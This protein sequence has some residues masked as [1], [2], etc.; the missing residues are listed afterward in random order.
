[1]ISAGL[2]D[3]SVSRSAKKLD[4]GIPVPSDGEHTI[5]VWMDALANYLTVA[6]YPEKMVGEDGESNGGGAATVQV[7]GKDILKFHAIYWPAFLLAAGL[8]LPTTIVAHAHWTLDGKK[9]AKSTG[10]TVDPVEKLD[11]YGTDQLRFF[12]LREGR[13]QDDADFTESKVVASVDELANKLGNLFS[14]STG[15]KINPTGMVPSFES[16]DCTA[17]SEEAELAAKV[18]ATAEQVPGMYEQVKFG[19]GIDAVMLL[20]K[21]ANVYFDTAKPWELAREPDNAEAQAKLRSVIYMSL[22]CLRVSGVL[23]QPVIPGLAGRL[24]DRMG[25]EEG[26]EHRGVGTLHFG[27]LDGQ[28]LLDDKTPL[29]RKSGAPV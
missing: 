8:P 7:I 20:L 18:Q 11:Q 2:P 5:Y 3:L 14:R 12:L 4:W 27:F 17:G 29:V 13:I 9:I 26:A 21:A 16:V 23:L 10:N 24:L 25:L 28:A 19:E 6:G 22:E 1:M 15:K